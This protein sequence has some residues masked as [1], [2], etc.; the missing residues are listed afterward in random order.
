MREGGEGSEGE[1]EEDWK[2]RGVKEI[3]PLDHACEGEGREKI[4]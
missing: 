3:R 4:C 1:R 2:W